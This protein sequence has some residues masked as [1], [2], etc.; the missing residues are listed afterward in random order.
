MD[1]ST[2]RSAEKHVVFVVRYLDGDAMR[3][4]FL[5]IEKVADG[6]AK[7]M[8]DCMTSVFASH[9]IST[10]K[11]CIASFAYS[12]DDVKLCAVHCT[13]GRAML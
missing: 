2:D 12:D 10:K 11:V 6:K 9:N 8:Y 7:T 1:E 4:S 5:Q 13:V 3:T